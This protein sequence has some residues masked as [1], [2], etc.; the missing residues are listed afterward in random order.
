VIHVDGDGG[1]FAVGSLHDLDQLELHCP[2]GRP[3]LARIIADLDQR[4]D[5]ARFLGLP[6]PVEEPATIC[7]ERQQR[8]WTRVADR[9][10]R[11][12]IIRT[13]CRRVGPDVGPRRRSVSG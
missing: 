1:G 13:A 9:N 2:I 7:I 6:E 5:V 12:K 11:S 4:C 3:V 10:E 8:T